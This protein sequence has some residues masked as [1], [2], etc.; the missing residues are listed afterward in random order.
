MYAR[1]IQAVELD[2]LKLFPQKSIFNSAI[3]FEAK[4]RAIQY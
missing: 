2:A 1:N 4:V 3:N